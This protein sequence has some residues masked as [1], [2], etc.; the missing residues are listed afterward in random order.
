MNEIRKDWMNND[1]VILAIDRSNRPMDNSNCENDKQIVS[2]YELN[3]PFCRNNENLTP[4]EKFKIEENNKWVVRCT[5]NKYPII[6]D[7]SNGI[8]GCHEVMIDTYR[9]NGTFYNM[10][11][12]EFK[13][14][15]IMYKHRYSE[16]ASKKNI[17][18]ISIFKN[19]LR[20]G[21][22]SLDHPHSQIIGMSL[23]P[24]D[25]QNEINISR[26][27]YNINKTCLYKDIIK[28]EIE[29]KKRVVNNS[30]KFL[31]IVPYASRYAGE[32]RIL[33]KENIRFEKI[34]NTY[35]DDLS[36]VLYNLFKKL[37]KNNGYC[38]FN[39]YI[40]THPVNIDC[41]E[42]FNVHIHIISRKY[43]Y[44]GFELS[45]GMYVSSIDPE[46]FAKNIRFD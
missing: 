41:N 5:S 26:D 11:K 2:G 9:H 30:N 33:F 3:C 46:E 8:K 16:F 14:L 34:D 10:T 7:K 37:Y 42:Y 12:E 17:E 43:N 4:N 13:K 40:H 15:L 31:V 38:P 21:G 27:Y 36:N 20:K 25:I 24:Q 39:I 22:A 45:T 6:D 29:Y 19:F 32:V 18:Y 35:I 23:L 1:L 28:K 44:G